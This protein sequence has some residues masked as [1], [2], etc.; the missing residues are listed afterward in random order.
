MK[1]VKL[2]PIEYPT[3]L[4]EALE[5][6]IQ[7]VITKE[8]YV[9]LLKILNI[10]RKKIIKNSRVENDLTQI[11]YNEL[12]EALRFG[13]LT[14]KD[15]M[16]SGPLDASLT[17]ALRATGATWD[18][19]LSVYRLP[20]EAL[21]PELSMMISAA[22]EGY[23]NQMRTV[24]KYLDRLNPEEISGKV[25]VDRLF[26]NAIKKTE[27]SF[28]K[29]VAAVTLTPS[30]T[31][32]QRKQITDEWRT[33]A[34]GSIKGIV[35]E[36]VNGLR[37]A[38]A[39]SVEVGTRYSNLTKGITHYHEVS[40][41]RVKLIARQESKALTNTYAEQRYADAGVTEYYW[42]S[43][44]GTANH[45]VR[46][47]HQALND[48][49]ARGT[50][51]RFDDP[52]VVTEPG[53]AERRENPGFDFNCVTGDS[54]INFMGSANKLFRRFYTGKL[55]KLVT[56]SGVLNMTPNHPVLT[57]RGWLLA[58]DVQLGDDLIHVV[59]NNT[60]AKA[61]YADDLVPSFEE[62]FE[63]S[64]KQGS[65]M[66]YSGHTE[67]FHGDGLV[68]QKVDVISFKE[69]LM[70]NVG[71]Q[72][73]QLFKKFK[74]SRTNVVSMKCFRP[75]L[76]YVSRLTFR[77]SMLSN[78]LMRSIS[79][80]L[81]F[82]WRGVGHASIHA[83]RTISYFFYPKM[84]QVEIDLMVANL[85]HSRQGQDTCPIEIKILDLLRKT[86]FNLVPRRFASSSSGRIKS[87]EAKFFYESEGID[88]K[89]LHDVAHQHPGVVQFDR[90]VNHSFIDF[91][92]HVYNLEN[93][94]NW[95]S[96]NGLIIHNCRCRAIPIVK[97]GGA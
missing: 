23:K 1:V 79:Q 46:P 45:P 78:G 48:A 60:F 22:R 8:I 75:P 30:I 19:R 96:C 38:V 31:D 63:F 4:Q 86:W 51:Y 85:I 91:S 5:R 49:S 90:V 83:F 84:E 7:K 15:G 55:C 82:F 11:Q 77:L 29:N 94:V 95:Y 66:R 50:V 43:V 40:K 93:K 33:R 24:T 71:V 76:C 53:E 42:R 14:Y 59:F 32:A 39:H 56:T 28:E 17:K 26:E 47:R 57:R 18:K 87:S 9:D 67:Q 74:F 20:E 2:R 6:E 58:K 34:H 54:K 21:T 70:H 10:K 73:L 64:Q 88:T 62:L 52:P 36:Q 13:N 92:G 25:A 97:F 37:K 44:H 16:F 35:E 65:L 3:N 72:V 80:S 69:G 68:D 12:G 81:A 61:N 27:K 41:G 89:V